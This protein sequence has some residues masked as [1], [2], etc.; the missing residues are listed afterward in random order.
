MSVEICVGRA[1]GFVSA[2]GSPF[3]LQFLETMLQE[4]P[5]AE[6]L[7]SLERLQDERGAI[8]PTDASGAPADLA[9]T[10]RALGRL[11]ALGLGDHPV[12][13]RACRYL[14]ELQDDEGAWAL[15][16]AADEAERIRWT[17]TIGG[18]LANTPFARPSVLRAAEAFLAERWSVDR[19]QGP[20]YEPIL[21]Y[22]RLLTQVPSELADEALQWCGRELERG[23]RT[24]VFSPLATARVYLRA[25]V[26]A[27]PGAS[28]EAS[29]LL[30]G[31]MT[32]QRDDG[33]WAAE[34]DDSALEA[35]LEAVEALLRLS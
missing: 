28:I 17:G 27:L 16:D 18:L 15:A 11:E 34:G 4:Q 23:F 5:A 14:C 32:E 3:D 2:Q 9:S 10:A 30:T 26:R 20:S 1:H 29:E 35:T 31:L 13:E 22:T 33:S 6:L 7:A 12:P 19:V 21:A 8:A 25:R 24:H